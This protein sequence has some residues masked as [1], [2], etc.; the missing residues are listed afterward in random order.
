M[1][2]T[3]PALDWQIRLNEGQVG[4]CVYLNHNTISLCFFCYNKKIQHPSLF[5]H[6]E[7]RIDISSVSPNCI[8]MPTFWSWL[9]LHAS[10]DRPNVIIKSYQKLTISHPTS[11]VALW[12]YY[13]WSDRWSSVDAYTAA[14]VHMTKLFFVYSLIF[15]PLPPALASLRPLMKEI[16]KMSSP[17]WFSFIQT[18]GGHFTTYTEKTHADKHT[19]KSMYTHR[20]TQIKQRRHVRAQGACHG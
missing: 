1:Q 19:H 7:H 3:T 5:N 9:E 17:M 20:H 4:V 8:L 2:Y 16:A 12:V 10:C 14:Y 6:K 15:H 13:A 11:P 18:A